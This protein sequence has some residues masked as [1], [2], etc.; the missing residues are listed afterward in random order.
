MSAKRHIA[1][2]LIVVCSSSFLFSQAP[3]ND[4]CSNSIVLIADG[5]C[6]NGTNYLATTQSGESTNLP[7][8]N[9]NTANTVWYSFV[10]TASRMWVQIYVTSLVGSGQGYTKERWAIEV[11]KS[12]ACP[13]SLS[14]M[15][16]CSNTSTIG[17]GDDIMELIFDDLEVGANYL[18]QVAYKPGNGPQTPNFCI[19]VG[20]N[21]TTECDD[22]STPCGS[23]CVYTYQPTTSEVTGSCSP[24]SMLPYLEG[25]QE[26]TGC[27]SFVANK[28]SMSFGLVANSTCSTSPTFTW[29]L[30]GNSCSQQQSGTGTSTIFTGLTAGETYTVCYT[31]TVPQDCYV[32]S[33]YPFVYPN[34]GLPVELV[35]FSGIQQ[36]ELVVLEWNTE[37]EVN[38]NYFVLQRSTDGKLF[39]DIAYVQ[40]NG[41]S[42][43]A[44]HYSFND[45]VAANG[46]NYYRLLQ[47]DYNQ[48]SPEVILLE[49]GTLDSR[50]GDSKTGLYH[51]SEVI[52][53]GF[54]TAKDYEFYLTPDFAQI[55]FY[56]SEP[57]YVIVVDISGVVIF[58][59][60]VSGPAN[61]Q[62]PISGKH[63]LW[64]ACLIK[65]GKKEL[66]AAF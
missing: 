63:G 2:C 64:Y 24:R 49:N 62:I 65:E 53:V 30:S 36:D 5:D 19:Q 59:D 29:N 39:T 55:Q 41:T 25:T 23:A 42:A 22:C 35:T 54:H 52:S 47:V 27:Y 12:S 20:A 16:G 11:Y 33:L 45:S 1:T 32:T 6:V 60:V 9:G 4:N 48:S 61:V 31:L 34:V 3:S 7:C 38:N 56:Q 50:V 10:A 37:A 14:N 18:V 44:N 51:Y 8:T 43:H 26:S 57:G 15:V 13:P 46:T 17:N 28:E 21:F 40:G 66:I 58:R